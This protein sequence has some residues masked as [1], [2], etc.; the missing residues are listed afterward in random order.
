MS[1][2]CT[3]WFLK[4]NGHAIRFVLGEPCPTGSLYMASFFPDYATAQLT[5]DAHRKDG[6]H[7]MQAEITVSKP[8]KK[9]VL[10][11]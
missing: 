5:C 9:G 7:V 6:M 2:H 1:P 3:T 11:K 8:P 10:K 4:R